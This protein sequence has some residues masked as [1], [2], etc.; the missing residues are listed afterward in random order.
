MATS[1]S[2]ALDGDFTTDADFRLAP[3]FIHDALTTAGWVQTSDTGQINLTT[4]AKPAG[5]STAAGYEIW[6]MNDTLQGTAP[7]YIKIE[8]GTGANNQRFA[9]WL[10]IGKGSNGSGTLTD[11]IK[12]RFTIG[13][14]SAQNPPNDSFAAGAS[15]WFTMALFANTS[16]AV[17]LS[18]ER[19][20][21]ATGADTGDGILL[22]YGGGTSA[23]VSHYC[24]YTGVSPT[25]ET[26][27]QYILSTVSPSTFGADTGIAI[28]IPM[29]GVAQQPGLNVGAIIAADFGAGAT[30][31]FTI[32]GA[33][34]TYQRM[35]G[36]T[37]LKGNSG[38]TLAGTGDR[39]ILRYE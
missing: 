14:N 29:K 3:Q 31:S 11:T 9:Y 19:T 15:S 28:M 24:A 13:A 27:L 25:A 8:Y 4:V 38:G 2:N 12:A 10:T 35:D 37:T 18:I 39:L 1:Y 20:K 5:A 34:H 32:Y 6:R 17:W 30:I 33:S 36:I 22:A 26:G 23:H 16:G 21:D 7:I